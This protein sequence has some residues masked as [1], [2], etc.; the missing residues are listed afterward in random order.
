MNLENLVRGTFL[1]DVGKGYNEEV[2][3][4]FWMDVKNPEMSIDSAIDRDSF[5][6]IEKKSMKQKLSEMGI[7]KTRCSELSAG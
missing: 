4:L 1:H 3:D 7:T 6:E 2:R 5:S